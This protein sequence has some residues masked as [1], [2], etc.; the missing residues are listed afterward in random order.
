MITESGSKRKTRIV[1][2][3][4]SLV[5]IAD[6]G[7]SA[8]DDESDDE[9]P[10]KR[11]RGTYHIQKKRSSASKRLAQSQNASVIDSDPDTVLDEPIAPS[12]VRPRP[13]PPNRGLIQTIYGFGFRF[14][15]YDFIA[16]ISTS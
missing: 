2:V 16:M 7:D 4:P 1:E 5:I 10:V 12:F 14:H 3:R 15:R 11:S 9:A 13:L 8:D 6:N